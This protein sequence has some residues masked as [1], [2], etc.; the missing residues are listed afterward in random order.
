MN[1]SPLEAKPPFYFKSHAV[2]NTERVAAPTSETEMTLEPL[3]WQAQYLDIL[4]GEISLKRPSIDKCYF[5][6]T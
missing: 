1:R 5:K 3:E 4:C 2:Y 6:N